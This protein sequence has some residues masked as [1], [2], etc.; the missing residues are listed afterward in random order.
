[1]HFLPSAALGALLAGAVALAARRAGSLSAS[2]A[3]AATVVGTLAAAAGWRW[4]ALLI[5]YFIASSALTRWGHATKA[6]RT[7][8][9]LPATVARTA[10]QV[11][12][13]GGIFAAAALAGTLSGDARWHL[14]ALGALAAATADTWATEIG[15]LFG[16]SPRSLLSWAPLTAGESGG[17]TAVGTAASVM[18]AAVVAA[19]T[20]WMVP[21]AADVGPGLAWAVVGAG[22]AG[23]LGDSVLGAAVQSKRWCA[24]CRDWTERSVHSCGHPTRHAK[25]FRWMTNDTVN[26][27]ATAIGAV[28]ALAATTLLD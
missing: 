18:A 7:A 24:E 15:T 12:A 2:G 8:S 11:V 17:V 4:A 3:V 27:F 1:M 5:G 14:A 6:A 9:M 16:G 23:S 28:T 10:V 13:N 22:V 25:G 19:T 26:L 21:I 20:A